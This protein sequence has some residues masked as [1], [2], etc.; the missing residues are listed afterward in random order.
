MVEKRIVNRIG[1]DKGDKEPE[2]RGNETNVTSEEWTFQQIPFDERL[3][4]H[5]LSGSELLNK[6]TKI[7]AAHLCCFHCFRFSAGLEH[8]SLHANKCMEHSFREH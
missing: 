3:R 6:P 7:I 5:S 4:N 1:L 2:D 8:N